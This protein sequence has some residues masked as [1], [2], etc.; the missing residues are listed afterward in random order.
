MYSVTLEQGEAAKCTPPITTVPASSP[1][2]PAL[3]GAHHT[4]D[5][6][7]T[8]FCVEQYL[9]QSLSVRSVSLYFPYCPGFLICYLQAS[10][11]ALS[12]HYENQV[13][14]PMQDRVQRAYL[15]TRPQ[16]VSSLPNCPADVNERKI[17]QGWGWKA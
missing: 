5:P 15:R 17:R 13:D 1:G 10:F 8:I 14:M 2:G 7:K 12:C 6:H 11:F 3:S 4:C 16:A 9:L